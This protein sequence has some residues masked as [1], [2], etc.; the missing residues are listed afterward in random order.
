M[1]RED[2][3]GRDIRLENGNTASRI[4]PVKIHDIDAT[5]K[6]LLESE[7]GGPIR[8]VEFIFKSPGVNRPLKPDDSRTENLNHTYYRDQINK[9]ANAVKEII[10]S[11]KFKDV[12]QKDLTIQKNILIRRTGFKGSIPT[13]SGST[14]RSKSRARANLLIL[15]RNVAG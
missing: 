3:F 8:S 9:V 15:N 14:R 7:L 10:T 1:A 4:F 5:D 12:N 6:I 11:L 2:V 13:C